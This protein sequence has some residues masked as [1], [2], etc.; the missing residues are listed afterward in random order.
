MSIEVVIENLEDGAKDLRKVVS[1]M[2][3]YDV[4]ETNSNAK[5]FGH[6]ELAEWFTAACEHCDSEGKA[7]HRGAE[8]LADKLDTAADLYRTT[9]QTQADWQLL[10][11]NWNWNLGTQRHGQ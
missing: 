8:S 6:K 4:E 5:S 2:E 9:D 1:S 3:D 10:L 11:T 7:L